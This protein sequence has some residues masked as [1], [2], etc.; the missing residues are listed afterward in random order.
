MSNSALTMDRE[1]EL[2]NRW[3]FEINAVREIVERELG[4]GLWIDPFAGESDLADVTNDLHPE[5][6]TDHTMKAVDFMG[7]YAEGQVDGGV[8]LDPP[9]SAE[10]LKRQYDNIGISPHRDETNGGFYGSVRDEIERICGEGSTVISCGW[11]S[12]G[13][14]KTRGFEKRHIRLVCHGSS[15]N[16]TIVTV[17]DYTSE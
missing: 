14:G 9:Y 8:L 4:D 1:W 6:D 16:D 7:M 12:T 10:Q 3:T 5:R 11:N 2:P 17:E 13:I 15:R